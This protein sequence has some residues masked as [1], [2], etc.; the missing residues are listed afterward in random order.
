M[1]L[2]NVGKDDGAKA[3]ADLLMFN[4]ILIPLEYLS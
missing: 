3:F 4:S 1:A 2:C